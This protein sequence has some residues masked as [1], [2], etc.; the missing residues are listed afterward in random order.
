MQRRSASVRWPTPTAPISMQ[1]AM[2]A[3]LITAKFFMERMLPQAGTH[4][5]RIKTGSDTMMA[6]PIEAF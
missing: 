2:E 4:L 1:P 3:K 6:M 5:A